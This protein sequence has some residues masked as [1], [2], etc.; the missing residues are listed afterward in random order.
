[1]T[2]YCY[3]L[4]ITTTSFTTSITTICSDTIGNDMKLLYV[5]IIFYFTSKLKPKEYVIVICIQEGYCFI[6]TYKS[7]HVL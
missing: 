7:C 2:T 6:N 4:Q 5:T 1:M 3:D